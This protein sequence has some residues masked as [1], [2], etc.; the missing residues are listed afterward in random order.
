MNRK[1]AIAATGVAAGAIAFAVLLGAV[2]GHLGSA[3]DQRIGALDDTFASTEGGGAA[4]IRLVAGGMGGGAAISYLKFKVGPLRTGRKPAKAEV[5]LARRAGELPGYVELS[6]VPMT[7]W[8]EDTL[9]AGNAPRLGSVVASARPERDAS[10]VSFDVTK[11]VDQPGTYAFAV[12]VPAGQ[13]LADFFDKDG[14]TP[15]QSVLEPSLSLSWLDALIPSLPAIPDLPDLPG[16]PPLPSLPPLPTLPPAFPTPP[17]WPSPTP[18]ASPSESPTASPTPSASPSESPTASPPPSASPSESPTAS[19]TP[20]ASPSES[21]T[22]SPTPSASPSESPTPSPTPSDP[23]PGPECAIG[24]KLVPTCGV[25]WGVAPGAHT[26]TPRD[27]ALAAFEDK[28]DRTQAV[29]HSY[30]RGTELFP[31]ETDVKLARDPA[32][33]RLLF[34]NWKPTGATWREI[35]D[36]DR[37]TDAYLD[38]LAAH[39]K[40]TFNEPFFFTVHHEPENDVDERAGSGRTAEDYAAMFRYVVNRLRGDGV[41]NLVSTMVFMA[42]VPWN[43]KPWFGDLY[44][45]DDVVDWV[46]WDVYAHSEPGGY[47]YGDFAEM[48]NRTSGSEPDWP[49]F[50]AYAAERFSDK[51]LMVSEWGV[52]YSDRDPGHMAEFYESVGKQIQSFPRVKAMVYFDTPRDQAGRDSR[53]DRTSAG[54]A[55]YRELGLDRTFQVDV[56]KPKGY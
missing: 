46:A 30:R 37:D 3:P 29:Y 27:Q 17:G 10:A 32:N 2:G 5:R 35:A 9:D 36:G 54:L 51:P 4:R 40:E 43:V 53:I 31:T 16:V 44:P 47:G 49:G 34:I 14:L 21:P 45:G 25:L 1:P 39:I 19:P 56:G 23:G 8:S 55:A 11:L 12:T 41:T 28:T 42:Y 13:G 18:S 15:A 38:R 26:D 22:A 50:Y 52:W 6:R 24:E 48:M 7:G 33:P 20:S